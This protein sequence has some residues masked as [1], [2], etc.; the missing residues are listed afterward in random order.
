MTTDVSLPR[1]AQV[2][3]QSTGL[4]KVKMSWRCDRARCCELSS[5]VLCGLFH[6]IFRGQCLPCP[7]QPLHDL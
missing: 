6:G 3:Q 5:S 2:R 4:S 1:N 7:H